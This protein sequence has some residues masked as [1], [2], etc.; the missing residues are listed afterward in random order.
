[1]YYEEQIIDGVLCW[2]SNPR[3]SWT[4]CTAKDLTATLENLCSRLSLAEKVVE[5]AGKENE[6]LRAFLSWAWDQKSSQVT[7]SID[8]EAAINLDAAASD[9]WVALAAYRSAK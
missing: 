4:P 2:R 3:D 1:V 6:R 7:F 8:D 9:A 5:A